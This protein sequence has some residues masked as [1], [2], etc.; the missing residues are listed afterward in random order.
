MN[1]FFSKFNIGH[2]SIILV[3]LVSFTY[4]YSGLNSEVKSLRGEVISLRSE[5]SGVRDARTLDNKETAQ[6][7]SIIVTS[8]TKMETDIGW[9]K[10]KIK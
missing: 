6:Q 9:I 2:A 7:L 3:W 8:V 1:G 10:N 4:G 5:L